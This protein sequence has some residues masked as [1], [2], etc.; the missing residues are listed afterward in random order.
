MGDYTKLNQQTTPDQFPIPNLFDAA[1]ELHGSQ[2]F[3]KIDLVRAYFNIPV[4]KEDIKKT[5]VISS[6]RLFEFLHMPLGLHNAPSSFARFIHQVL[7]D[8]PFVFPYIDDLLIF[9]HNLSEHYDHPLTV[10]QRLDKFKLTLN[11]ETCEFCVPKL[12]FLGHTI[13]KEGF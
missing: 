7:G 6:A 1:N 4:A 5:A 2:V 9:S 12:D 13:S 11:L 10:F 3:S 8:L